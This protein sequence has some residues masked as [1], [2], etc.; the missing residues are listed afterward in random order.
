MIGPLLMAG[1]QIADA[2]AEATRCDHVV[3]MRVSPEFG[4]LHTGNLR[5][6]VRQLHLMPPVHFAGFHPD[7]IGIRRHDGS[8]LHGVT[9][10]AHSRIALLGYLAGLNVAETEILF[11]RLSFRRLGYLSAF[12]EQS[13]L[14]KKDF[15]AYA[16]DAE[17]LLA[18]WMQ[19]GCFMHSHVHPRMGPLLGMAKIACGMMGCVPEAPVGAADLT[20]ELGLYPRHPVFDE[21]AAEIGVDPVEGFWTADLPGQP[22][23]QLSLEAFI[24]GSFGAFATLARDYLHA[25]SGIAESLSAL[26]L[27]YVG[28]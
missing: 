19:G 3:S 2:A 13:A 15:A 20:D 7:I 8:S 28:R 24:E 12:A 10:S 14:L 23:R 5:Q 27:A 16:I 17:A 4:P 1:T 9:M 22:A 21:I 26:R 6:N 18:D 11:N 25:Q